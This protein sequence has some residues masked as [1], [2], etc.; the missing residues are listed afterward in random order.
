MANIVLSQIKKK[1]F[2]QKGQR[3]KVAESL[4]PQV[5]QNNGETRLFIYLT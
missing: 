5:T 1:L 3:S 2:I 4:P